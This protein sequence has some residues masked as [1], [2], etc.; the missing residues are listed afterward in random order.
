MVSPAND[1]VIS[2]GPGKLAMTTEPERLAVALIHSFP[3][4]DHSQAAPIYG[5][6]EYASP[7]TEEVIALA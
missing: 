1:I 3:M 5:V 4:H 2:L 6:Q 7:D